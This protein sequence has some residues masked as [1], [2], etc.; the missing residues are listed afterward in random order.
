MTMKIGVLALQGDFREHVQMLQHLDAAAVT[1][2]LPQQLAGLDGLI[3]PGG[4]STVMGKLMVKYDLVEPLRAFIASGKPVWGTCAGLILLAQAT[5]N[6]MA[7]QQLLAS[8]DI[9]VMRNA[10]GAQRE[11]FMTHLTIPVLGPEPFPAVFIR[12][13]QVAE[14]RP[15]VQELARLDANG[16]IV[17]VRQGN[18]LGTAFHPEI[19]GDDRFHRYFLELIAEEV[20]RSSASAMS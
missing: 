3:I 1:V 14:V 13:P 17:A 12:G 19:A 18:L 7:G 5:D 16:P 8:L 4:E 6:G 2:K 9:R 20:V 11:S 10:F 15:G